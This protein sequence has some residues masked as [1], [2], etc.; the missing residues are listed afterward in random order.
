MVDGPD[1]TLEDGYE[2]YKV[3]APP[4]VNEILDTATTEALYLLHEYFLNQEVKT[5][6]ALTVG[7]LEWNIRG[8]RLNRKKII[9]VDTSLQEAPA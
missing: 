1:N 3:I 4:E 6:V 9:L 5:E 2:D 7:F 8:M